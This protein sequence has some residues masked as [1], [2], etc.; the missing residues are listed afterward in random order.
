MSNISMVQ[1]RAEERK[2][3]GILNAESRNVPGVKYR[4]NNS[5]TKNFNGRLRTAP[6]PP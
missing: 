3:P 1:S 4:A 2:V 6:S 5:K